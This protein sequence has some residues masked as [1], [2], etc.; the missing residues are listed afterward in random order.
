ME[1]TSAPASEGRPADYRQLM[2]RV[3]QVVA[4]IEAAG[5]TGVAIQSLAEGIF[6]SLNEALGVRGARLYRYADGAYQIIATFPEP[7]P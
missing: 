1:K 6:R 5:E 7:R 4:A 3:E 2:R